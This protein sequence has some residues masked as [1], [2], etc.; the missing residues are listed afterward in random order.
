MSYEEMGKQN[1][2][3]KCVP[4]PGFNVNIKQTLM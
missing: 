3:R 4:V 2:I 1:P